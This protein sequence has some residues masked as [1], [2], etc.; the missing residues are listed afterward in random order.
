MCDPVHS[1]AAHAIEHERDHARVAAA[2]RAQARQQRAKP[3]HR[4]ALGAPLR[5]ANQL[6]V[7]AFAEVPVEIVRHVSG[8]VVVASRA[9]PPHGALDPP[10]RRTVQRAGGRRPGDS[11]GA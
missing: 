6:P 9:P 11:T 7:A 3:Q 5:M 2:V 8:E 4:P 1:L 10:H